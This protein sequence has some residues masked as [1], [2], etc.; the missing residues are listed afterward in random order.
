MKENVDKHIEKL[1]SKVMKDSVLEAPSLD[2]TSQVMQQVTTSSKSDVTLYKP[3]ITKTGWVFLILIV[4]AFVVFVLITGDFQSSD[5][6]DVIDFSVL[7]NFKMPN[8]LSGV[9]LSTTSL[10]ALILF[11]IMVCIQIPLLK[12][13]FDKRLNF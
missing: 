7:S 5:W 11:G 10:Y 4:L 9:K 6:F 12:N 13:Y 1:V 2:F 8:L 3:L